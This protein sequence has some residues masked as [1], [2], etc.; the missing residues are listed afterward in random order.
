M[1]V[2]FQGE[3]GAF[4]EEAVRR[5]LGGDTSLV[6][7]PSFEEVFRSLNDREVDRAVVPI[8]NSLAGSVHENYD[9]LLRYRL[10]IVAETNVRIV[11]NLIAAPGV[12]FSK[13]Q[14][15]FSHPVA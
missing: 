10:P 9:L 12:T 13:V 11:H 6:P 8:E 3:R 4:S 2:A 15:V 5:L 14:R 7:C 1:K